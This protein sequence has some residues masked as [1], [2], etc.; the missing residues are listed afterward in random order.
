VF[1]PLTFSW[2]SAPVQAPTLD[3]FESIL[4][5]T[6]PHIQ[7][8][9][10]NFSKVC[11]SK[12][13][14][15][16]WVSYTTI[17]PSHPRRQGRM[18]A[19]MQVPRHEP[20][21]PILLPAREG[22]K[23]LCACLAHTHMHKN[24]CTVPACLHAKSRSGARWAQNNM[25][26]QCS[27]TLTHQQSTTSLHVQVPDAYIMHAYA[28]SSCRCGCPPL[29]W[30]AYTAPGCWIGQG[31]R[32]SRPATWCLVWWG[33]MSHTT[34]SWSPVVRSTTQARLRGSL[35]AKQRTQARLCRA[36]LT[37]KQQDS[38]SCHGMG[39]RQQSN[40]FL[41]HAPSMASTINLS[42]MCASDC[43]LQH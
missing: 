13:N 28:P 27:H 33:S 35:T 23:D 41:A 17:S 20:T 43:A 40:M 15:A 19:R 31:Q 37:A 29:S 30:V 4:L 18:Q 34:C 10:G 3:C 38:F 7:C 25:Q 14:W 1:A 26:R 32:A 42:R 11:L 22:H 2:S 36:S 12:G 8:N 24:T 16:F 5:P 21:K 9:N 6:A 39:F